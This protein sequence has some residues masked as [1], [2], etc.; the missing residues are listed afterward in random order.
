[1][2]RFALLL[3]ISLLAAC[4]SHLPNH[5]QTPF[6]KQLYSQTASDHLAVDSQLQQRILLLGDAG[7]SSIEPLQASLAKAQ[8]R[9]SQFADKTAIV[10]L[11]DNIYYFGF[12]NKEQGQTE[13]TESQLEDISHLEAQLS[14]A[15]NSGAEMFVVP[16]NHDW[17][18]TQVDS[19]AA[20]VEQ[21]AIDNNTRATFAPHSLGQAPMPE[22]LHRNGVS[23]VFLDTMWMIKADEAQYQLA[24][25]KLNELLKATQQNHPDNIVL[26]SGHHPIETM[27]PHNK[28]YTSAVY[29]AFISVLSLFTE[30]DQ[31]TDHPNYRRLIEGIELTLARYPKAI[32]AAG[33][34]HSLQVFKDG[35]DKSPQYRLVSGA[36]N[37][38]KVTGVGTNDNSLFALAQE[39]FMEIDIFNEQIVLRVFSIN[40]QQAVFETRLFS[41]Q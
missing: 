17:Y 27:G 7:H 14:I 38:S 16:G 5:Q 30:N 31:D 2:K 12:P 34:E 13:Y 23:L 32:Y 18:A 37:S 33:H 4:G 28:Y 20:Y 40:Q 35:E 3:S 39:G 22:V 41:N 36:A 26:V 9:A 11:G 21:Y 25:M 10:M 1:M 15:K 24:M 19:Q 6:I 8:E 29:K